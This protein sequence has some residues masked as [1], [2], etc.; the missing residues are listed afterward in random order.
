[1]D[2]SKLVFYDAYQEYYEMV[3]SNKVFARYCKEVYGEDFSQD[4]FSNVEQIEDIL[5]IVKL[6]KGKAILDIGCGNGKMLG[7]I[8][9]RT[10]ATVHGFDYSETAIDYANRFISDGSDNFNFKSGVIGEVEYNNN[11]FDVIT[12]IDSIY[13]AKDIAA[14]TREIL[15]WLK[16]NGF[17]ICAYQEG[18]VMPKTNCMDSSVFALALKQLGVGYEVMDYTQKVYELMVHKRA[19]L[20]L[21]S[22]K[23]DFADSGIQMWYDVAISQSVGS[24]ITYEEYVKNNSR[25]IYVI[26]KV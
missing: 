6:E 2:K 25:Y 7:Y 15:D 26:E 20:E 22:M 8:Q 16:P 1:M 13:F 21:E 10:G 23:K 17:F 5:N 19:I 9:H 14:F 24:D 4:G 18:D 3:R 12:A 11:Q